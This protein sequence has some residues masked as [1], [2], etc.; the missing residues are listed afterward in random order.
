MGENLDCLSCY[1]ITARLHLYIDRE[2]NT[3]EIETVQQHLTS[4]PHCECRFHFDMRVK[5]LVHDCC[6]IERAP[7]HLREKVMRIAHGEQVDIDPELAK[8]IKA[9]WEGC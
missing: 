3:Q 4:C 5:R 8:K 2:L 7:Q 6:A 9:D 1:E